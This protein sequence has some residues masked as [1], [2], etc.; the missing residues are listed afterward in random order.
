MD[1]KTVLSTIDT[2]K[3]E[4]VDFRIVDLLGRQHHVTVPAYAVDEGTFRN[5][6]AFDGS[7]LIGYKSIEE[8]DMVAM[9]DPAT[10][11]ID[12]FVEAKTMNIICNIVNPDNT[13]YT[14]DPR[15]IALKAEAYLQQSGLA[16]AAYFGPES[17]FF[18]FDNVRYASGPSGSFFHIDSEEAF[19]NTGKEGQN[20]GYKVRNKGGYFPVQ[21]TDSQ[22]DIRNEM[23]T[24]MT[25]CGM[26]V[27]R[28]HHEVATAGQG[29][30]NFRFDTLTRTADNLLLFKYIVRN[31]AAKHGKTATFMPKPIVGDNGSG[32]HVHQSLFNGDTP[33]FHEQG[34]YA[35]LSETALHYIGGILHHAPALIALTN[36]STN[37]FKRLV[38]GY[39][40][41][42]NLVFSKGN[43]SAAVRIPIA[44]V[45]P[46]ASRIEFRT[47]D[48]TANPYLA[49]AA[50]LMA[51]LDGIKR[52]LDPRELG[53]GPLDKNIYDL[54]DAEKHEIKSAP[55]SLAEAL[56]ALEQDH[57]FLLE[58]D[59]FTK[60]VIEGWIAQ[61]RG[62]IEQVERTVNPKEYELYYDL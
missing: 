58:G 50:M 40:A 25:K 38:P 11:F 57:D 31:V 46:K 16:T 37:S 4:Y 8:S 19:W 6:V 55:G 49:F 45:T 18:L 33:L 59:V 20:L 32:M 9:P 17:E 36:P 22:M 12:P 34:G 3:V 62:E 24:L 10:A 35:N 27:E 14:R 61:K 47:P 60:E 52:K 56:V 54:S 15:G 21:P 28:H 41:P 7:S 5:G 42:V 53:F 23:C 1:M 30:I 13:V 44:A 48:S 51:G 43:R 2:E 29:E 39:E 26:Y